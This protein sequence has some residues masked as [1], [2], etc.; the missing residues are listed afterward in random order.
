MLSKTPYKIL[1]VCLGNICRSPTAEVV[2]QH[3]CDQQ[4][5]DIVIDSAGTSNYHPNKAPDLRSQ[6][7][8]LRR[9]YDLSRVR[10]RQLKIED[11]NEF[12]LILAMDFQNL[13]DIHALMQQAIAQKGQLPIRAKVALMSEHDAT[14]PKQAL[15][16]P[17]YGGDDDF[18]QV[19]DQCESSSKAW[20]NVLSNLA[21]QVKGT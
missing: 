9:G 19:L 3:F 12:D 15:P 13:D 6:K 5:L 4:Q 21:S 1:C 8:A 18:E 10:A 16:D 7:H 20:V 14:Y 11:F 2:L 17:Y